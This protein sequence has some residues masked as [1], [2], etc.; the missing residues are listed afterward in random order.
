M[1]RRRGSGGDEGRLGSSGGGG[2]EVVV[3][4]CLLGGCEGAVTV[5]R[6]WVTR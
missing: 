4:G 6:W 5:Y 3:T 1:G 2:C